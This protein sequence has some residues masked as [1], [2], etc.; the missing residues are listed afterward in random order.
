MNL[1]EIPKISVVASASN[2]KEAIVLAEKYLPDIILMDFEMPLMNGIEATRIISANLNNT[3]ILL[4]TSKEEKQP[5]DLA[6]KA[7]ARGYISKSAN[8]EDL[9][10]IIHLTLKGYFQFG[11]IITEYRYLKNSNSLVVKTNQ[12]GKLKSNLDSELYDILS[13]ITSNISALKDTI[14]ETIVAQEHKISLLT[15]QYTYKQSFNWKFLNSI[16]NPN[17]LS[18]KVSLTERKQNLLFISG[19]LL[20]LVSITLLSFAMNLVN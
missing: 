12:N 11:L 3:K 14:K 7:G 6:L 15:E 5:I 9:S 13:N 17:S 4:L 19:F 1:E 20:G 8:F 18:R 2:G 10:N 16:N